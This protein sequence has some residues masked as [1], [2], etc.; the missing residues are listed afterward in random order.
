MACTLVLESGSWLACARALAHTR[1][2]SRTLPRALLRAKQAGPPAFYNKSV[3]GE[4]Y[5]QNESF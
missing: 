1:A 3:V 2:R 4:K 5:Q